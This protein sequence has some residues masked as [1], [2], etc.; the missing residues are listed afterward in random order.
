M[1]TR[2]C[3]QERLDKTRDTLSESKRLNHMLTERTQNLERAQEDL[4]LKT[5]ELEK[6]NRTLKE[7]RVVK[8]FFFFKCMKVPY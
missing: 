7:V 3:P 2:V 8:V 1:S 5:S 4:E 6:H